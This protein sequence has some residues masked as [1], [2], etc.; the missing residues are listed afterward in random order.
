MTVKRKAAVR[1]RLVS[2]AVPHANRYRGGCE[3]PWSCSSLELHE[4]SYISAARDGATMGS[5]TAGGQARAA[6]AL[7][8]QL[9][10]CHRAVDAGREGC[11]RAERVG[12]A[13][14]LVGI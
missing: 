2:L 11:I 1:P 4:A 8:D 14:E 12:E 7:V 9:R 13:R 10:I 6:V 5:R 3:P